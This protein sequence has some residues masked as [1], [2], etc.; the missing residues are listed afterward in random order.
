MGDK[1]YYS[2]L[3][4]GPDASAAEVKRA[5][6]RLARACHPDLHPGDPQAEARFK[7]VS[8]AAAVLSDPSQRATY[9]QIAGLA[10]RAPAAPAITSWEL[11]GCEATEHL[12]LTPRSLL[13]GAAV[14]LTIIIAIALAT[15]ALTM[16]ALLLFAP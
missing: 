3:G 16:G 14:A 15:V 2:L 5:Y 9:D 1:C 4:L 8:R 10:R 7:Q 11:S 12:Q 6:R 13:A